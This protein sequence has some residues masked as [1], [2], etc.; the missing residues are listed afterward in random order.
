[1]SKDSRES[2]WVER[3]TL[4]AMELRKPLLIAR[5]DDAALPLH[6]I[7]RQYHR[8]PQADR[9]HLQKADRRAAENAADRAAAGTQA[10]RT[11]EKLARP[12][13]LN[14]FKYVEQLPNG[15]ENAR[16]A[17][18]CST[19]RRPTPTASPS[20]DAPNPAFQANFWIGAGGVGRLLGARLCQAACR[21]SLAAISDELPA[22]R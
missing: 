1:M 12:N 4:M 8:L 9:S 20:A 15:A 17:R 6:L 14:F 21:R 7:N 3:E 22:L 16:V 5:I 18:A 13:P 10:A 2:E 11:A 19:G